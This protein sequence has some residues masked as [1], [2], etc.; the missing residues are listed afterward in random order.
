MKAETPLYYGQYLKTDELL[1]LQ[2]P[3]SEKLG[4]E[5]H[6]EM[7]FI[8]IHQVYELW[9]RQILHDLG[10]VLDF[11][12]SS[13]V[14]D[15]RL[16]TCVARLERINEIQKLLLQQI[17]VL[18]TM[19]PMDFLDFRDLLI[20]ASGFQ[21]VQFRRIE[22]LMGLQRDKRMTFGNQ[23]YTARLSEKD[24]ASIEESEKTTPLFERVQSW[25]ERT[26]FLNWGGFSFWDE[27]R[28]AVDTMLEKDRVLISESK[29]MSP[30]FQKQ[31]LDMLERTRGSFQLVLDEKKHDE[32]Q[33]AGAWRLSF[34]AT[35]AA[36]FIF[37]YRDYPALQGPYRLLQNLIEIDEA[38][39]QWR[40]RHALMAQ[41]MIGTK[42]G[43]GGSSG[44]DYLQKATESHKVFQDFTK[45]ST[46][47]IPRAALPKLPQ[48]LADQLSLVYS[49]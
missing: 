29:Q 1:S 43:T 23:S 20:P 32:L 39:T 22:N 17:D 35:Q 18:E 38:W 3:E 47:F 48:K 36:L 11:F 34:A 4:I 5:A 21:S 12:S 31:Q 8:V 9:F 2:K 25:L 14:D 46:F 16:G 37:L 44:S 24:R 13:K 28:Q 10:S 49:R 26:P 45:L 33:A 30:E 19:T 41:R 15:A 27:Y 42:I 40:Y 7:L 6:D